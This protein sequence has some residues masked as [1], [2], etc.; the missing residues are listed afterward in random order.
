MFEKVDPGI[1]EQRPRNRGMAAAFRAMEIGDV[2]EVPYLQCHKTA[3]MQGIVVTVS[4]IEDKIY[5]KRVK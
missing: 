2:I 4:Q 1:F 3:K 5:A